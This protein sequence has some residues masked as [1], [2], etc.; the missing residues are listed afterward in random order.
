MMKHPLR[1]VITP[2]VPLKLRNLRF[3]HSTGL[4]Q[5]LCLYAAIRKESTKGK[6]RS[7]L[8]LGSDKPL[9]YSAVALHQPT[10]L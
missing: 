8:R 5:A 3:R 6:P 4:Q 9:E 7:V 2:A 10:T 1:R